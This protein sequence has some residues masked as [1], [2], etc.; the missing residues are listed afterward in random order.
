M[1]FF[2]TPYHYDLLKDTERLSAFYEAIFDNKW[3]VV[4]DLGTGS[5]ILSYF[6]APTSNFIFALEKNPKSSEC[7]KKNLEKWHNVQVINTDIMDFE[8]TQKAD[9]IICEMLDTALIDEE[10][11]PVLN[12]ALNYLKP[13][14]T[15]IPCG[16]LNG[17]EPIFMQS[18]RIC[19]QDVDDIN[20]PKY[21][22]RG[23]LV[24]FNKI[25]FEPDMEEHVNVDIELTILI[26]G[27]I[28]AIKL[29]SFTLIGAN[30]ICGPTP[31]LNPPLFVPIEEI[32]LNKNEKLKLN[33]SY[34][35]GGGL[36]TIRTKIKDIS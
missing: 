25:M 21:Q 7:A 8:F 31:M 1:K 6:A 17:A 14:G 29:T 23:N 26:P 33:L 9:L 3:D 18:P 4:Y 12:K 13:S 35:M 22:N 32:D 36:D 16:V 20:F 15:V 19:Y 24:I 5:G 11:I 30:L 28:N 27:K 34:V 10:Q 2:T